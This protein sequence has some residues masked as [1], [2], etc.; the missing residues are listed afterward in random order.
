MCAHANEDGARR[1]IVGNTHVAGAARRGEIISQRISRGRPERLWE[2]DA[3][4]SSV[5]ATRCL[6]VSLLLVVLLST[7]TSPASATGSCNIRIVCLC[8]GAISTNPGDCDGSGSNVKVCVIV[9]SLPSLGTQCPTDL[10]PID[11]PV[12]AKV[13]IDVP[14][15]TQNDIIWL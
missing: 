9:R 1:M 7:S 11:L 6:L 13:T 8:N 5:I 15:P 12:G 10:V 4:D 3:W 2:R 14:D